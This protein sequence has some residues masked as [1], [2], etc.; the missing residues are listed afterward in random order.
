MPW[1]GV[2]GTVNLMHVL[3]YTFTNTYFWKSIA[4][5]V[6]VILTNTLCKYFNTIVF[7]C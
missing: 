5:S 3:Q 4:V 6:L 7:A 2:A 1:T